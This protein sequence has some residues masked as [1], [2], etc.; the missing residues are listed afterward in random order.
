MLKCMLTEMSGA[1]KVLLSKVSNPTGGF[2]VIGLGCGF[3]THNFSF[4]LCFSLFLLYIKMDIIT[5]VS[6]I[7]LFF[8]SLLF[9]YC[10]LSHLFFTF[11]PFLILFSSFLL[12]FIAIIISAINP[13]AP[14][15]ISFFFLLS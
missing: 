10:I 4:S 12:F 15:Y 3:C 8:L 1:N 9:L 2:F 13:M 6:L 14:I 5:S 7:D 11:M